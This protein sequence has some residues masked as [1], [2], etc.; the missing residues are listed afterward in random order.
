MPKSLPETDGRARREN[1]GGEDARNY[2]TMTA[3]AVR[4][5]MARIREL[6]L[7]PGRAFTENELAEELGLGKTPVREALLVLGAQGF[8]VPRPR[9]GYRVS[10]I[11]VKDARDNMAV[12][13]ALACESAAM[14][15][16]RGLDATT[17][18]VLSDLDE[19]IPTDTAEDIR[20]IVS[21][22]TKF[23]GVLAYESGSNR[24][25][26]LIN[27][28]LNHVARLMHLALRGGTLR[29]L[30]SG[31]ADVIVALRSG[32]PDQAAAAA[33]RLVDAWERALVDALLQSDIVMTVNVALPSADGGRDLDDLGLH[34]AR[35]AKAAKSG[36]AK[37]G[38]SKAAKAAKATKA[39]K[40]SKAAKTT[41][42]RDRA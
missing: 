37:A 36:T 28:I 14:T 39:S 9:S 26:L 23:F 12:L 34:T 16:T 30:P 22:R 6:D 24:M 13:R 32:D 18:L 42:R 15:A 8:V 27:Q 38:A 5:I 1:G 17:L 35:P 25:L 33:R 10:P 19:D 4:E 2:D 40:A 7:E 20:D 11:T 3:R 41:G 21:A 31:Q 29:R